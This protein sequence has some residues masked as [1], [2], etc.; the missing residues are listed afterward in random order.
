MDFKV[1][2]QK[3]RKGI[4]NARV[5]LNEIHFFT[6]SLRLDLPQVDLFLFITLERSEKV[7]SSDEV[8]RACASDVNRPGKVIGK[9]F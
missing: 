4:D 8:A 6:A 5:I 2:N 1:A 3:A 7:I 9:D